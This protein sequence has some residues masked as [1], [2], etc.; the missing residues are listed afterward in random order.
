MKGLSFKFSITVACKYQTQDPT[1]IPHEATSFVRIIQ[2]TCIIDVHY[3]TYL[4]FYI[5]GKN[6]KLHV[7]DKNYTPLLQH[8]AILL[9]AVNTITCTMIKQKTLAISVTFI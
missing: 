8:T 4:H 1:L 9:F 2:C 6:I 5:I 3:F 7:S